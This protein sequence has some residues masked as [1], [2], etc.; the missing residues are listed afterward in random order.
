MNIVAPPRRATP[1]SPSATSAGTANSHRRPAVDRT[2][3]RGRSA[4][5]S[6]TG[7]PA[8]R[9]RQYSSWPSSTSPASHRRC[10]TAKSAYCTG[11][12]ASGSRAPAGQE[13]L[14]QR[15][16]LTPENPRRPL[17]GHHVVHRQRQ[18][19]LVRGQ[20]G[21]GTPRISGPAARSNGAAASAATS[22]A[23]AA[24][25]LS[26]ARHVRHR[27]RERATAG[28]SPGT[29]PRPRPLTSRVR[30]TSC[31]PVSA[32]S[33][34]QSAA[35]SSP[36]PAA[37]A[38][39]RCTRPTPDPA[40]PGT[41]AAA[42]RTTAAAAGRGD[43]RVIGGIGTARGAPRSPRPG[44]PRSAGRTA[45]SSG[46]STPNTLRTREITRVA[47]SEWPPSSKKPSCA[48]TR[49]RPSTCA[50]IPASSSSVGRGRARR[51]RRRSGRPASGGGQR[52]PVHLPVRGQRQR[53]ELSEHRRDH[54]LRQPLAPGRPAVPRPR[55]ARADDRRAPARPP[56]GPVRLPY[57]VTTAAATA[58][59][60]AS[61]ASISPGSTRKPRI[62]TCSSA[63]PRNSSSPSAAPPRQVPGPV[64]PLA[65]GTR[66][67][68]HEPLRGQRRT[69]QVAA[70]QARAR[71][72]KLTRDA[73]GHQAQLLVQH[74]HPQVGYGPPMMLRCVGR[75]GVPRRAAGHVH[76]RLGDA[77]HVD[78]LRHVAGSGEPA[79][80][81]SRQ[82]SASPPKIT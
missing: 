33:A 37:P 66:T 29:A 48:P 31:R 77:V 20:P 61:T 49:S 6:S 14:V 65:G 62:L 64:H 82:S 53:G 70:R 19:V 25:R 71:D 32:D 47:S 18:H 7:S 42:A 27:Q 54:V 15:H 30:S 35:T 13:R 76:R 43:T 46:T 4:G 69:V 40:G 24:P 67:D 45:P 34:A 50:Q 21:P 26:R 28:R 44:R 79:R 2:G 52:G 51:T 68:R 9:S 36:R 58:G 72:V 59:C 56:A 60:A 55:D 38:R 63:R 5:S 22:A 78:Q 23:A 57:T 8:S 10:H 39:R 12:G 11:N 75:C 80:Q 74:V 16:Q 73:R 17:I 1:R 81:P 41:T 3:G